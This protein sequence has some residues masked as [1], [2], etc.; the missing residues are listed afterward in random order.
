MPVLVV[1]LVIAAV[2]CGVVF[3]GN[4]G[5]HGKGKRKHFDDWDD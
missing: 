5:S 3:V 2:V 1:A 4:K